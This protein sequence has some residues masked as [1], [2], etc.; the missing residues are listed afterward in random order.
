VHLS[1]L[2]KKI[3]G[4]NQHFGKVPFG[5]EKIDKEKEKEKSPLQELKSKLQKAIQ[6]E[7]FE[8]AARLR[9]KIRALEN[10]EKK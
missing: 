6:L 2:L 7:E 8:E 5:G 3:H 1:T 4:S 9:D 10:K